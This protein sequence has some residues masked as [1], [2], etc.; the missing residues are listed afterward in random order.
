MGLT[1]YVWHG[2]EPLSLPVTYWREVIE[3]QR[4]ILRDGTTQ[5]LPYRNDVQTNLFALTSAHL[6][7]FEEEVTMVNVSFDAA[8]GTRVTKRGRHTEDRVFE[9]MER[10]RKR[11]IRFGVNVVLGGHTK[12]SL[13]ETYELLKT[14][15]A[16]QMSVIPLIA[17]DH[18]SNDDPFAISSAEVVTA[19]EKL[20]LHWS[21]DPEPL[22]V[23]PLNR[24]LRTVCRHR[25]NLRSVDF[26]RS[27]S[28]LR[29]FI[30]DTGGDLY[31]RVQR[32]NKQHRLGNLFS[33]SLSEIFQS[34]DC[35]TSLD[36]DTQ[37]RVR[38]CDSC[39]FR[40][41]CDACPSLESNG[42]DAQGR[43]PVAAPLCD[44][45]LEDVP[46]ETMLIQSSI[47]EKAAIN[48]A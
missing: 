14:S 44:F 9:N 31:V 33:Q 16:A 34:E 15:G 28:G 39:A 27:H 40:E 29:R 24:Y 35:A 2:G 7:L 32:A 5:P 30:V 11:N 43:C 17:A 45:I 25:L 20:Y 42:T 19:L 21:S 1:R 4:E 13:I 26:D 6:D 18:F 48:A 46:V 3:L 41:S 10:L 22:T 23:I 8:P 38:V 37:R 12:A 47:L 36:W